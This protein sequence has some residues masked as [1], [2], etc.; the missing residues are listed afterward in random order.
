MYLYTIKINPP[1]GGI[2]NWHTAGL[3]YIAK[4]SEEF[5]LTYILTKQ[6]SQYN[7]VSYLTIPEEINFP[8][9]LLDTTV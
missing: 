5:Q 4:Y 9:F 2:Q 1:G 7:S 8:I 6:S 3:A